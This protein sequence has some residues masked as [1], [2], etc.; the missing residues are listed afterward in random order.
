MIVKKLYRKC[1]HKWWNKER[2]TYENTIITDYIGWF[3]FG[4]IP[5]YLVELGKNEE[6]DYIEGEEAE[7]FE[8]KVYK[9]YGYL[10][11]K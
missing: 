3:L 5:I 10:V 1:K 4:C 6:L 7:V 11:R 9:D 8:Y 2:M